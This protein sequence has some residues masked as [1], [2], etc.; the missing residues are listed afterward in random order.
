MK[1]IVVD[2]DTFAENVRIGAK[3]ASTPSTAK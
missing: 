2:A 1:E 3:C